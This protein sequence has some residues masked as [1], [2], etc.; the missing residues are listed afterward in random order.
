MARNG[1]GKVSVPVDPKYVEGEAG[2]S[3]VTGK[4]TDQSHLTVESVEPAM[5]FTVFAV[6]WP[7]RAPST[8][9]ALTAALKDGSLKVNRPDGK[10]DLITLTNTSLELK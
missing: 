2:D 4:W 3:Y 5:E 6:L 7:Q 10:T 8:P 9:N 1:H